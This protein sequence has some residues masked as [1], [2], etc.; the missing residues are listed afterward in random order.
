M[1]FT[2]V[3][4][5][6]SLHLD[7]TLVIFLPNDRH[8]WLVKIEVRMKPVESPVLRQLLD[9][10][11][12]IEA[13]VSSASAIEEKSRDFLEFAKG[14][15]LYGSDVKLQGSWNVGT[16]VA[17][18][19]EIDD[20]KTDQ[21]HFNEEVWIPGLDTTVMKLEESMEELENSIAGMKR[22]LKGMIP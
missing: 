18:S 2:E 1:A 22:K 6:S 17:P 9:T 3:R 7:N 11:K 10:Q 4:S 13:A 19:L 14:I 21:I 5:S 8:L 15:L 20:L 16:I 12:R